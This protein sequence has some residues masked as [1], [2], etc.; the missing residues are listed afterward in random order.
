MLEVREDLKV[1]LDELFSGVMQVVDYYSALAVAL[2]AQYQSSRA[3]DFCRILEK[4]EHGIQYAL[5][6]RT[7]V[8]IPAFLL[9][10][11]KIGSNLSAT[12]SN[13]KDLAEE[14]K[15]RGAN[16]NSTNHYVYE[17]LRRDLE[18]EFKIF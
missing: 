6:Q 15:A 18:K 7:F 3:E 9:A 17:D 2:A 13:W 5:M 10:A 4:V 8:C 11:S 14:M 1:K 16:I 12:L